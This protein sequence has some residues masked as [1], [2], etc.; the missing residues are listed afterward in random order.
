M[1]KSSMALVIT[2]G[3]LACATNDKSDTIQTVASSTVSKSQSTPTLATP[4][5]ATDNDTTVVTMQ[6]TAVLNGADLTC[7]PGTLRANDTLTL[8]METPHGDYLTATQPDK[9]LFFIVYP[10]FDDPSR[11]FS[12]MPS[13]EFKT[14]A[15]LRLPATFRAK[16]WIYGRDSTEQFFSRPGKYVLWVGENLESDIN[17]HAVKC[18]V[19]F[20]P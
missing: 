19:V 11:K 4:S 2:L 5:A 16:P 3:A 13:E 10:R 6:D 14:T 15:S 12:L 1:L 8:R 9:T 18:E 7:V 17:R 20:Q